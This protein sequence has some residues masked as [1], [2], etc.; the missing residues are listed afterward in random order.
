[1]KPVSLSVSV[2]TY[3]PD[4]ALLEQTLH[5]L[6]RALGLA[7][8]KGMLIRTAISVIDNG[9]GE[10]WSGRLRA[11]SDR[12]FANVPGVAAEI[13]SGHGNVGYGQGHNLALLRSAA[14]YHLVLNPDV[15][16]SED[17]LCE[18]IA[19]M[20]SH[21]EAGLLA[22]L[23]TGPDGKP[24]YLCKRYPTVL[25]LTLR[26]FAPEWAKRLFRGRLERYEMKC[27]T[28]G[29]QPFDAPLAS[30]CFMFLRHAAIGASGG[31]R[32]DFFMYFEDFDLSLRIGKRARVVCAP[33]VRVVHHGG[34]AAAKGWR[35][36]RMFLRSAVIFFNR[37]GWRLW[38]ARGRR[39][40]RCAASRFP[41][42]RG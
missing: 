22:P 9:P 12:I 28:D 32:D 38:L 25:D 35:H 11:L 20:Q 18:A 19:F 15:L 14:D 13:V 23:V 1:M 3:A 8:S 10:D 16:L 31:F 39:H 34:Y 30:G 29:G 4:F 6:L 7:Q 24:Q 5:S 42:Q 17:A 21:A 40:P 26:G 2:V 36:V 37:N 41:C 33:R 27:E